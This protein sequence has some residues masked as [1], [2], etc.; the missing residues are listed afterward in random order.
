MKS[1][2]KW[3]QNLRVNVTPYDNEKPG[4]QPPEV[5]DIGKPDPQTPAPRGESDKIFIN[6]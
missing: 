5:P 3:I 1:E 6:F 2:S 4:T